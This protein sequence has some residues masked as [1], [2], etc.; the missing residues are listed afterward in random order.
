MPSFFMQILLRDDGGLP[1]LRAVGDGLLFLGGEMWPSLLGA[2][3]G[4]GLS[5]LWRIRR[6]AAG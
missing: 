2:G 5:R 3:L 4:W 6:T 1:T